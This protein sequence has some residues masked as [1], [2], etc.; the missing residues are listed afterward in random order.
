MASY[1]LKSVN[2]LFLS[3]LL[4]LSVSYA[5]APPIKW[6]EIP[7]ADLEMKTYSADTNAA[8]VI[9]CDFGEST[10]LYGE[11]IEFKVHKRIKILTP[12]GFAM[13]KVVVYFY[14]ID[15]GDKISD[16]DGTTY[17]LTADGSV[18]KSE[19]KAADIHE[20]TVTGSFKRLAFTLPG[21][22]SGC[23]FEYRYKILKRSIYQLPGWSFQSSEP[24][25]WSEYRVEPPAAFDFTSVIQ[26]FEPLVVDENNPAENGCRKLRYAMADVP[27]LREE[28]YITTLEDYRSKVEFQL[29]AI[30]GR[31]GGVEKVLDTWDKL[32]ANLLTSEYFG[33][34]IDNTR[35]LRKI[36]DKITANL[37]TPKEK[38]IAL[39]NWIVN[40]IVYTGGGLLFMSD[41]INDV[42]DNKKGS[43]TEITILFISM[44]RYAG[45]QADPVILSTRGNG[46]IQGLYPIT[47]QFNYVLTRAKI[48]SVSYFLDPTDLDRSYDLLPAKV[49]GVTGLVIKPDPIEWVAVT[50]NNK[51]IES[52]VTT[53]S[54]KPDGAIEGEM[55]DGFL[56]Y[57]ALFNRDALKTQKEMELAKEYLQ[58]DINGIQID[59][60]LVLGKDSLEVP[61]IINAK[62]KSTSYAQFSGNAVFLNPHFIRRNRDNPFK[63]ET[64]KFPID[65]GYCRDIT[66]LVTISL[67]ESLE[68]RDS[69]QNINLSVLS[70]ALT[71]SR[72]SQYEGGHLSVRYKLQINQTE[73]KP[74]YYASVRDF[75]NKVVASESETIGLGLRHPTVLNVSD[76]PP[77]EDPKPETPAPSTEKSSK[78]QKR[79]K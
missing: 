4:C 38:M 34:K 62:I 3:F 56:Q 40:T 36:V 19:L 18:T 9:L 77:V 75:I 55:Q 23:V 33:K 76:T 1:S 37:T 22:T 50:S 78:K 42:L 68:I 28:P 10:F 69:L 72:R 57:G 29:S 14:K 39:H 61:F 30:A 65:F 43:G 79:G 32:V 60:V 45:I 31:Y 63:A 41:E 58:T 13:A 27:A 17:T 64:R 26:G 15:G 48:D 73:I 8:A 35:A 21:V 51:Y 11:G 44:L 67:P 2:L 54:L 74:N 59:S 24:T 16:I 52:T 25:R 12:K 46:S 7:R 53:I 6:G 71:Y 20:E 5:Q 66:H 70:G 49:H 47:S